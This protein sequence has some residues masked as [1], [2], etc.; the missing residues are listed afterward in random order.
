MGKTSLAASPY[1]EALCLILYSRQIV[2]GPIHVVAFIGQNP[3]LSIT[4]LIG[5]GCCG[6]GL[7][8]NLLEYLIHIN[9]TPK[10]INHNGV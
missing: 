3:T 8:M 6:N 10:Q 2:Q 5:T 9:A 4:R 7:Y 1:S